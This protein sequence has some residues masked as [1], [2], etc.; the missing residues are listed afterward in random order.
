[1]DYNYEHHTNPELTAI[2]TKAIPAL[3]KILAD[4][5][6]THPVIADFNT[7]FAKK[8]DIDRSRKAG[9]WMAHLHL[10]PTP[11]LKAVLSPIGVALLAHED[12]SDIYEAERNRRVLGVGC[13]LLQI[14]AVQHEIQ[15][16]LNLNGD[17]VGDLMDGTVVHCPGDAAKAMQ[18]MY[19][20]APDQTGDF[21]QR[22][23]KFTTQHTIYDS[24]FRLPTYR[25]EYP[26]RSKPTAPIPIDSKR[27]G[28]VT[29]DD[30]PPAKR[31]RGGMSG[32]GRG[33]GNAKVTRGRTTAAGAPRGGVADTTSRR[34]RSNRAVDNVV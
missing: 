33:R 20:A 8:K 3:A 1:M 26:S 25:R 28:K 34:L 30:A 9:D 13:A 24:T 12:L 4:F 7:F 17:I 5:D 19:T 6:T 2:F 15:E 29:T 31:G 22:F 18:A 23:S 21:G 16:P 14:L 10:I 32:S 11:E 27:K